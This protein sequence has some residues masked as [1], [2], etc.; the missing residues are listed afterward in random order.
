MLEAGAY[1]TPV[2]SYQDR[3]PSCGVLGADTPELDGDMI[4]VT[5]PSEFRHEVVELINSADARSRIGART[6]SSI[7]DSHRGDSWVRALDRLYARAAQTDGVSTCASTQAAGELDQIV[8]LVQSQ[9]GLAQGEY[10][11]AL[12]NVHLLPLS[13]RAS[14]WWRTFRSGGRTRATQLLSTRSLRRL[15]ALR[16]LLARRTW[17]AEAPDD[18]T[19]RQEGS[20]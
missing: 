13:A 6:A 8:E 12:A 16:G 7:A 11:A 19:I 20:L 4:V 3:P 5:S 14:M 18:L 2:I 15:R 17:P 10:G 9:T 1:G